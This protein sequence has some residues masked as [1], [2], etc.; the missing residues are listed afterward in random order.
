MIKSSALLS[1]YLI[2]PAVP[3]VY[4]AAHAIPP[5]VKAEAGTLETQY[6]AQLKSLQAEI[7]ESLPAVPEQRK[8]AFLDAREAV[9]NAKAAVTAAQQPL[10]KLGTAAALVDHAKGKWLGGAEKGIANAQAMLKKASSD[11]EREAANKELA[12]WQA[13]KEAGLKALKERQAAL[14][15]AMADEAK[16]VEAK[17]MAQAAL[18]DAEAKEMHSAKALLT[19]ESNA[20]GRR[21]EGQQVWAGGA[22]SGRH[23]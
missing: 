12:R 23:S 21:S 14:D 8:A 4:A 20:G 5:G 9:K 19:D 1:I 6:A 22:D 2:L 18:A 16:N 11:A 10:D 15:A 3:A 7:A 13:D 17:K